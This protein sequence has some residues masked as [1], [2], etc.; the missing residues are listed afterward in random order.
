MTSVGSRQRQADLLQQT[1][2]EHQREPVL[3]DQSNDSC[4]HSLD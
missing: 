1:F 4:I 2:A 3:R